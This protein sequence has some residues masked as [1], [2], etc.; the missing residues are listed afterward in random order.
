[1]SLY[2]D[3]KGFQCK[4]NPRDQ[5]RV[6]KVREWRKNEKDYPTVALPRAKKRDL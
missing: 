2:V 6:P 1:M 3:G 4:Q 5:A